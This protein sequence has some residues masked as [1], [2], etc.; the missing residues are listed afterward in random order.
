MADHQQHSLSYNSKKYFEK[1]EIFDCIS[2]RIGSRGNKCQYSGFCPKG[3]YA[4]S[5]PDYLLAL[6]TT[7]KCICQ[8]FCKKGAA[9]CHKLVEVRSWG[10]WHWYDVDISP[11]MLQDFSA[12]VCVCVCL[13]LYLCLCHCLCLW[14]C[15][16]H[17][18]LMH[19]AQRLLLSLR[20]M[21]RDWIKPI[22]CAAAGAACTRL[23]RRGFVM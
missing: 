6:S 5:H 11:M 10:F 7:L 12:S 4:I 19:H 18:V 3:K 9:L 17:Y 15:L 21:L 20:W 16:C 23:S 8:Q 22:S 13:R 1:K 2:G 14:L